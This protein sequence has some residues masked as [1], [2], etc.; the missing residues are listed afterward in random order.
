MAANTRNGQNAKLNTGPR[1]NVA[2][3]G[4]QRRAM[5][6]L[7]AKTLGVGLGRFNCGERPLPDAASASPQTLSVST[8]GQ[9]RDLAACAAFI[10]AT[11]QHAART[12][13]EKD[14]GIWDTRPAPTI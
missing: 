7:R 9:R 11:I 1:R 5:Q 13:E 14:V 3:T 4:P 6:W 2:A 8:K 10:D 12:R